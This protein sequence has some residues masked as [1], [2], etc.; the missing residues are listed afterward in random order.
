MYQH[1]SASFLF[2][3]TC[4]CVL[5]TF[6]TQKSLDSFRMI[7][8]APETELLL[9]ASASMSNKGVLEYLIVGSGS[10]PRSAVVVSAPEYPEPHFLSVD[11][12]QC[13]RKSQNENWKC[14][15]FE[16]RRYYFENSLSEAVLVSDN[17]SGSFVREVLRQTQ[18]SNGCVIRT[19]SVG[20]R[21]STFN[22]PSLF[23]T[24]FGLVLFSDPK[25]DQIWIKEAS[26]WE[27]QSNETK[28][29]ATT[30]QH[31]PSLK[32]ITLVN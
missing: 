4:S 22:R 21:F 31:L 20:E 14:H 26:G 12:A 27:L 32:I 2:L 13:V 24:N 7:A 5:Q 3:V 10:Y 6:A 18:P 30:N 8:D 9:S 17:M 25:C 29:D 23:A 11:K 28:P 1:L 19:G 16:T 15:G